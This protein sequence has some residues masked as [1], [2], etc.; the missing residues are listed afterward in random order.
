MEIIVSRWRM[1]LWA[2][3]GCGAFG[4]AAAQDVQGGLIDLMNSGRFEFNRLERQAAVANQ[5]V[6]NELAPLC[7]SRGEGSAGGCSIEQARVFANVRELVETA[8]EMMGSGPTQYSLGLDEEGLGFAMRWTA[9]EEMAATSSAG[10]EFANNQLTSLMSRMT[11]LRYGARGF[12]VVNAH[13]GSREGDAILAHERAP[14]RAAQLGGGAAADVDDLSSRW[15][16]FLDAS[17]GW[18]DRD[19]TEVEDAF[20]FDGMEWT[21][22]VD[23]RFTP[24]LV[25]GAVAGHTEQEI[26]FDSRRSVVDGGIESDGYSIIAYALHE[27]DGPYLSA[28][29]GW[30]RLSLDTTRR[31]TYPSFNPDTESTDVT[32]LGS[33]DSTTISATFNAGWSLNWRAFGAEPYVRAEYR[34]MNL[35]GF[36]E[37]S[38]YNSGSLAGQPAGFDFRFGDQ[39][40]KS[41]DTALGFRVQYAMTPRFG[42]IVPYLKAE[43]HWQLEDDPHAVSATYEDL[44]GA[45]PAVPFDIVGDESDH[46]FYIAAAGLSVVLKGGWQGFIQYQTVQSLDLLSNTVITGGVRS[47]F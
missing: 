43:Y 30:Q 12:S 34:D 15:G 2:L 32:A 8:N 25:V 35:D 7:E 31:I 40:I 14:Q 13:P 24:A 6:Y 11:A 27:W 23:Y 4:S 33:T 9:A 1:V 19:P 20:D 42:V 5:A 10:S 28:S 45:T 18:G 37:A 26:D 47:E 46:N 3:C 36:N 16:G 21:F 44:G 39:D 22:G 29:L 41:F 38:R 17:Y